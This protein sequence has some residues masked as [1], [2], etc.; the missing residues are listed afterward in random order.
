MT[1]VQTC[2]LPIYLLFIDE[3]LDNGTDASGVE[4]SLAILKKMS[5]ERDKN[6]FIISHRDELLGRADNILRVVKENGFTS[7]ENSAEPV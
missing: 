5:R 7:Y 3:L 4:K 2:A 6:I 1:G